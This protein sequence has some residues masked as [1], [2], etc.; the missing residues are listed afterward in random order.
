MVA[1]INSSLARSS[2]LASLALAIGMAVSCAAGAGGSLKVAQN[3]E[4]SQ[5]YDL[6]VAEYTKLLRANPE[7]RDAKQGL[8]RAKLRASQVHFTAA[9]RFSATGKLEEALVEYRL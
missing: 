3:A 9:R 2:R 1:E 5:N 6:A 7:S 4:M 8:E